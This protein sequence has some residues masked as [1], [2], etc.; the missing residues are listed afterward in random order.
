MFLVTLCW[1]REISPQRGHTYRV[2]HFGKVQ[3]F[4]SKQ[5]FLHTLTHTDAHTHTHRLREKIHKTGKK[6]TQGYEKFL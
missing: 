5:S 4:Q 1:K 3:N 6:E 2:I